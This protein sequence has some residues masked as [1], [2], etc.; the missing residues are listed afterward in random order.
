MGRRL[1]P[2]DALASWAEPCRLGPRRR[3]FDSPAEVAMPRQTLKILLSVLV[4]SGAGAYLLADTLFAD[5]EALTYFHTADEVLT[6]PAEFGG[7]RIRMGGHVEKGSIL[8]RKGTLEYRFEVKPIAGMLKHPEARDRTV[9]VTYSGVVPDTFK[10]D[11]EVIVTGQL[12]SDGVF[13]AQD[14]VAKCPSKYEAAEK[15]AKAY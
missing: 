12:G 8:Q 11:A 9:T 15:N 10:D 13:A 7:K 1:R 3:S 2:N 14:L 4:I 5:P 6:R